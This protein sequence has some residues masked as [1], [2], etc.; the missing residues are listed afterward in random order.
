MG[1]SECALPAA[2]QM[3][4]EGISGANA[5]LLTPFFALLSEQHVHDLFE[6]SFFSLHFTLA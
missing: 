4:L 2:F 1:L 6:Q 3:V 5:C